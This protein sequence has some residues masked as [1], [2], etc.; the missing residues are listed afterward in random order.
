MR[1]LLFLFTLCF[2]LLSCVE[3]PIDS[4]I[5]EQEQAP[6]HS[7][8]SLMMTKSAGVFPE[9]TLVIM[10]KMQSNINTLM[11]SRVVWNDSMYVLAIKREDAIFLG[12]S[13]YI[14]NK[15]IEYVE[16]LNQK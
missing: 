7:M 8:R 12:V 13:E 6:S 4:Q 1:R 16:G 11:M 2:N 14:Y 9:D 10:S 15:Y 5:N 3:N